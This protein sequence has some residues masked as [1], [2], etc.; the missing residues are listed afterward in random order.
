MFAKVPGSPCPQFH[1]LTGCCYS[2]SNIIAINGN[3]YQQRMAGNFRIF[4]MP[5]GLS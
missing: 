5:S 2:N 3:N 4:I 1:F